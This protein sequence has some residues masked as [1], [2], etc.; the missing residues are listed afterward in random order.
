MQQQSALMPACP[1]VVHAT[2]VVSGCRPSCSDCREQRHRSAEVLAVEVEVE[3]EV[4]CH[5][6]R[7]DSLSLA[8]ATEPAAAVQRRCL[9]RCCTAC[10]VPRWSY[11]CECSAWSALAGN[12]FPVHARLAAWCRLRWRRRRGSGWR[13]Q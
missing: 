7:E 9:W 2:Q 3:K 6:P 1:E 10:M 13:Q 8:T 11:L 12:R 4:R 5:Q